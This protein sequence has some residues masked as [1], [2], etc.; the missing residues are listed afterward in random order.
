MIKT[1]IEMNGVELLVDGIYEESKEIYEG[2]NSLPTFE[3]STVYDGEQDIT[4]L[5]KDFYPEIEDAVLSKLTKI[6]FEQPEENIEFVYDLKEGFEKLINS[7]EF[8]NIGIPPIHWGD[9]IPS[10]EAD[11][12]LSAAIM[13]FKSYDENTVKEPNE[14]VIAISITTKGIRLVLLNEVNKLNN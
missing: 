14:D 11:N 4:S 5:M 1:K 8:L 7:D 3:I 12:L 13:I 2:I 6:N 9:K 10:D